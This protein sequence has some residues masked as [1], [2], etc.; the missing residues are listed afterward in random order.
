MAESIDNRQLEE[1]LEAIRRLCRAV[2]HDI[3]NPLSAVS[4]YLQLTELRLSQI[5][6]GDVSG[7]DTLP[8]FIEKSQLALERITEM[9]RR[10]DRFSK[11][12]LNRSRPLALADLWEHEIQQRTPEEKA[13]IQLLDKSGRCEVYCPENCLKTIIQ[14]LLDNALLATREGGEVTVS[15]DNSNERITQC[16][17]D[18]GTGMSPEK[19]EKIFLPCFVTREGQGFP[20]Q[21]LLLGLGLPIV[22]QCVNRLGGDIKIDSELNQGT[23]VTVSHPR[24]FEG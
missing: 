23:Q 7:L 20:K 14:E 3:N 5:R 2:I 6:S 9:V 24:K 10:L 18:N 8:E 17:S 13:R 19:V 4:G 12:N 15:I 16:I 11:A 22:Y 21:G 1:N